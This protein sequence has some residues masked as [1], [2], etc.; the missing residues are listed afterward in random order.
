MNYKAKSEA[1][2]ALR[3]LQRRAIRERRWR[4]GVAT[5]KDLGHTATWC[6]LYVCGCWT[7]A[8]TLGLL[9]RFVLKVLG[10]SS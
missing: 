9:A 1:V 6:V 4:R 10:V 5:V 7:I 3:A 2:A 8:L